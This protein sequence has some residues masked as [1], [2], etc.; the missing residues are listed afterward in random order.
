MSPA[1]PV[2]NDRKNTRAASS[3]PE[4]KQPSLLKSQ[5]Q[6]NRTPPSSPKTS[7][8]GGRFFRFTRNGCLW[9]PSMSLLACHYSKP[10]PNFWVMGQS[11]RGIGGKRDVCDRRGLRFSLS[12][13]QSV[14]KA[15]S[16][17][18]TE[19]VVMEAGFSSLFFCINVF[20]LFH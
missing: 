7:D 4:E 20:L 13:V 6:G 9:R 17:K 12:G 10:P 1:F 3:N 14:I 2:H 11:K 15:E 18:H 8:A 19:S 16:G 5:Q